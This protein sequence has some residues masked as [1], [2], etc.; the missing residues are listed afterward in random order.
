M[1]VSFDC[2]QRPAIKHFASRGC[3]AAGGDFD[4]SLG[5]IVNFV[6]DSE[7]RLHGFR[8][9]R[10]PYR[11][12]RDEAER[13]FRADEKA[14]QIVAGSIHSRAAQ[15]D[16]LAGGE[17]NF[18]RKD[19]VGGDAVGKRVRASRVFG[20]VAADRASFLA[21]RIGREMKTC[22]RDGEAYI[23]IDD[24]WL[25][26]SALVFDI[27]CKDA[28]HPRKNCNDTA[29]ASQRAAGKA[30]AGTAADNGSLMAV[31]D[32]D[33]AN[34]LGRGSRKNDEVR[35]CGFD[36]AIVFVQKRVFRPMKDTIGAEQFVKVVEET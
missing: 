30:G 1:H 14:R 25:D 15:A 7:E 21:R 10:E 28:I 31:G 32:F 12:F 20:N 8:Q 29:V 6:E 4:Y 13:S 11:D 23:G 9:A 16:D 2:A 27:D 36:G 26:R 34:D 17:H 3:D 19:V 5:G 35:A 33:Q 22:V 24:T 18:H